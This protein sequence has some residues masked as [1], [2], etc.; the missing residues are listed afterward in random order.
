V[1]AFL[2]LGLTGAI[3]GLAAALIERTRVAAVAL[4][5]G[6]VCPIATVEFVFRHHPFE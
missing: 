4:V 5:L 1:P 6:S 2:L 3:V